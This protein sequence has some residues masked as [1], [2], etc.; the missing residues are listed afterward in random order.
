M[1][2]L[3]FTGPHAQAYVIENYVQTCTEPHIKHPK[4]L[5]QIAHSGH[6][7]QLLGDLKGDP[8]EG[9][10]TILEDTLF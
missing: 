4:K 3:S 6:I 2:A 7:C 5:E 10:S 1:K 9:G 8:M